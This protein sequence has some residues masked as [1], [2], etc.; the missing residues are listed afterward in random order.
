[1]PRQ[2]VLRVAHFDHPHAPGD[3]FRRERLAHAIAG[4]FAVGATL[5]VQ[6]VDSHGFF[7]GLDS[8]LRLGCVIACREH[9]KRRLDTQIRC[10]E[11][12]SPYVEARSPR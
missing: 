7:A 2:R 10:R 3:A 11:D 5:E 1:M 9:R 12:V 8:R 6:N 4:D